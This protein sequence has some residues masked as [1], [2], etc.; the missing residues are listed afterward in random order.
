MSN[1][2]LAAESFDRAH[3]IISALNTLSIH[4]KMI[5]ANADDTARNSDVEKA[6][7]ELHAFLEN[8]GSLV[9]E[10]ERTREGMVTG[11]DPR[12]SQLARTFIAKRRQWPQPSRLYDVPL[13]EVNRLLE[14]DSPD[15]LRRLVA[16]LQELRV[17]LEQ[18]VHN[19]ISRIL[20][21]I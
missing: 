4:A 8:L 20:G 11:T 19:D 16:Y 9:T 7:T 13:S 3:S 14:S 18:N 12:L 1:N 2:W 6:R 15:D 17:L 10:A 5:L 21:D